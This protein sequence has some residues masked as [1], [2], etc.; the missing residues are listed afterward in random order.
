MNFLKSHFRYTKNQRNG[1]FTLLLIIATLQFTYLFYEF[2]SADR[3]Y[4]T[5]DE[6]LLFQKEMDSLTRIKNQKKTMTL[7][8]FNPNYI[9]DYKGYQLGMSLEAIDRLHTFRAEG[10]FINS[11]KEF[12]ELTKISDSLL[13]S[14]KSL[15]KFPDFSRPEIRNKTTWHE[16]E[17]RPPKI[18][19]DIN[20]ADASDFKKLPGIGQRLAQRIVNY[21]NK[22]QGYSVAGQLEEVWN[23]DTFRVKLVLEHFTIYKEPQIKKI[24]VNKATFKE[25]LD[26]VYLDYELTQKILQYRLEVAEI[27]SLEEL[28]KIA[29][30]P[31]E[32]F[33]R[34]ALY[35]GAK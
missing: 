15:F 23:L 34:I 4:L 10:N 18:K 1:I 25:L 32:K 16:E 5:K 35:L 19:G 2:E 28:K 3:T 20:L 14:M 13:N 26:V 6:S 17:I 24:D 7:Y 31:L 33:D 21:R 9:S 30:F 27:Q 22:L 8:P 12:Q 11:A 29:G